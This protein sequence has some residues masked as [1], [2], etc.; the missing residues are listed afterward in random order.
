MSTKVLNAAWIG[1]GIETESQAFRTGGSVV[2]MK[3]IRNKR[4]IDAQNSMKCDAALKRK[5]EKYPFYLFSFLFFSFLFIHIVE[6][7]RTHMLKIRV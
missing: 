5:S 3:I 4:G 6:I 7:L 1:I 2:M